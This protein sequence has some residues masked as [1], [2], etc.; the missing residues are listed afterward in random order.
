[1]S[2]PE[3][4]KV[5]KD[6]DKVTPNSSKPAGKG[7]RGGPSN[8]KQYQPRL[9]LDENEEEKT[10]LIKIGMRTSTRQIINFALG[11]VKND[12]KV[13]VADFSL[14]SALDA[15]DNNVNGRAILFNVE[16]ELQ[17][18]KE[19]KGSDLVISMLPASLHVTVAKDCIKFKKKK[20]PGQS[21]HSGLFCLFS[22]F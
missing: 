7:K 22:T 2:T 20:R 13:T 4:A 12:W 14:D 8:L 18:S 17:R 10:V 16:D 6:N 1:M 9:M 19:I 5:A 15:V 11:K 3:Q 21:N